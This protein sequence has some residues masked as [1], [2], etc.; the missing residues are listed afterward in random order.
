MITTTLST[1]EYVYERL[2]GYNLSHILLMR[3][4]TDLTAT[5]LASLAG[6]GVIH[7]F[8]KRY[9]GTLILNVG[10]EPQHGNELLREGLG[11]LIA[12]GRPFIANP[13]LVERIRCNAPFN[14]QR[15]SG[16]YGS[17]PIGYTDYSYL[18]APG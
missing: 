15:P 3:Q 6:D 5:P 9:K 12:F 14:E 11:D 10:I 2:N 17:S 13:D 16:Y 18:P 7:H 8:R 4:M 1:S